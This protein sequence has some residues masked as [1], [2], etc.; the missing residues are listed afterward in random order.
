MIFLG[1][2]CLLSKKE[3]VVIFRMQNRGIQAFMLR[4]MQHCNGDMAEL[5]VHARQVNLPAFSV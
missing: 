2:V 1:F 3:C 5:I 4:I